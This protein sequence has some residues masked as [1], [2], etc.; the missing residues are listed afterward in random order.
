MLI[1]GVSA[2][3]FE[4]R[5]R[6]VVLGVAFSVGVKRGAVVFDENGCSLGDSVDE[7]FVAGIVNAKANLVAG[8]DAEL[9]AGSFTRS[10][11]LVCCFGVRK[12]LKGQ[13][14]KSLPRAARIVPDQHL[15]QMDQLVFEDSLETLNAVSTLNTGDHDRPLDIVKCREQ[16]RRRDRDFVRRSRSRPASHS[17]LCRRSPNFGHPLRDSKADRGSGAFDCLVQKPVEKRFVVPGKQKLQIAAVDRSKVSRPD[18]TRLIK[19]ARIDLSGVCFNLGQT[20]FRL[21]KVIKQLHFRG[22]PFAVL[23]KTVALDSTFK[24]EF[25]SDIGC[26]FLLVG[27][28]TS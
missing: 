27:L 3:W 4:L 8:A 25:E 20:A 2:C 22:T 21:V 13:R 5:D 12:E 28:S 17:V 9:L 11:Q 6:H 1:D 24:S 19:E 16:Q 23:P 26:Q 14:L 15:C 18:E 7:S 10:Y